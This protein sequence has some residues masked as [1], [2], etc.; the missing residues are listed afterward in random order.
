[1]PG[2]PGGAPDLE[3]LLPIHLT[4]FCKLSTAT[5]VLIVTVLGLAVGRAQQVNPKSDVKWP[6]L[7]GSA[8]PTSLGLS[9]TSANYGQPFH[10]VSVTPNTHYLC[11]TDGWELQNLPGVESDG[12]NG[13]AVAGNI[14][15]ISL[16]TIGMISN[17]YW[18][19]GANNIARY[20]N[21]TANCNGGSKPCAGIVDPSYAGT[22]HYNL[23]SSSMSNTSMSAAQA[24]LLDFRN[25]TMTYV[26]HDPP[27]NSSGYNDNALFSCTNTT[28]QGFTGGTGWNSAQSNCLHL[29]LFQRAPGE[30][31]GNPGVGPGGWSVHTGVRLESA[32][33]SPGISELLSG[34]QTKAGVGDNTGFYFYNWSYGG[35]T[36]PSDEGNHPGAVQGGETNVT[37]AGTVGKGGTGATA[38]VI[39]CT[40]DCG[41]PG[42]GRYLLDT[43]APIAT[44]TIIAMTNPLGNFTPGTM[45]LSSTVP[46]S[47][48]WGTLNAN[49]LTPAATPL[50]TGSTPMKFAVT[51]I[52]G[53]GAPSAGDLICF[54]GQFHEQAKIISV[55]G[56]GTYTITAS[57]RH[58][59]EASSWI[60]DGGAC[61]TFVEIKANNVAPQGQ[62][63][64]FPVDVI[65]STTA[66]TLL[67][68]YFAFGRGNEAFH[69]SAMFLGPANTVSNLTNVNGTVTFSFNGGFS[70]AFLNATSLY[71]SGASDSAFNGQCT[72][73]HYTNYFNIACTQASSAGHTGPATASV[74][75]G[76][77]R[78][79]NT[80]FNLWA[81]AEVLD[82]NDYTTSPPS[83]NGHLTLEP[84]TVVWNTGDTVEQPHHYAGHMDLMYNTL[85]INNPTGIANGGMDYNFSGSGISGGL[86]YSPTSYAGTHYSNLNDWNPYQFHGGTLT[87]P[88]GIAFQGPWGAYF[89]AQY[90]P[91]PIGN[92]WAY[93]GCPASGCN[94]PTYWYDLFMAGTN[95]NGQQHVLQFRPF[96]GSLSVNATAFHFY[97]IVDGFTLGDNLTFTTVA[98]PVNSGSSAT[99]GGQLSDSTTYYY[100]VVATNT[101]GASLRSSEISITTGSNIGNNRIHL[102]W[103][104]VAGASG[105]TICRG[106]SS[107]Q[108]LLLQHNPGGFNGETTFFDDLGSLT[109][110]G[111][112][113]GTTNTSRGGVEQ[114]AWLGA[115]S[116]GTNFEAKIQAPAGVAGNYTETLP[117]TATAGQLVDTATGAKT[118]AGSVPTFS[119]SAGRLQDSG[120]TLPIVASLTTKAATSDNV[121]VMGMTASGHCSLTATNASA[122]TNITT[123]YI[124]AKTTNKVTVAHTAT[125]SM[126]YDLLCTAY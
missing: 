11:G 63:L 107:G 20:F 110:S 104:R 39:N 32:V 54:G 92:S 71:F 18:G 48:F 66:N 25:G 88:N 76:T 62:T 43:H 7:G 82:V 4:T 86:P 119:N 124:S 1:M 116:S 52:G 30:S 97:Q 55:A 17:T 75:W 3:H 102:Q 64:R 90:A 36:A 100:Y 81:G 10:N 31:L 87:P 13:L 123:T 42:D 22:E 117:G 108:E 19:N 51:Q 41:N 95:S 79:G 74:A 8:T 37:Y 93:I 125:A 6:L 69:T 27:A 26:S 80:A 14:K 45:T 111:T 84:N 40:M 53:T 50:G 109:S 85:V 105:Y 106:L 57:L 24:M 121:V 89:V 38:V 112:C 21:S 33:N 83:I 28:F 9:C 73:V 58:A 126:A 98:A 23:S 68:R 118:T 114:S 96:Q 77:T 44:G 29:V 49:V 61:G 2:G 15:S 122:A 47:P 91:D 5:V 115:N 60:V 16:Q 101:M 12:S 34:L 35:A 103:T 67:Y 113:P 120:K 99:T 78:Y 46:E 70:S 72:N 59:H 65:G 94:D 56:S